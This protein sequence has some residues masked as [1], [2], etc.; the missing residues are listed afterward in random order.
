[1]RI[2]PRHATHLQL[3]FDWMTRI[4]GRYFLSLAWTTIPHLPM[5]FT[6]EA[7]Q[8]P[9]AEYFRTITD[10]NGNASTETVEAEL[11]TRLILAA[12]WEITDQFTLGLKGGYAEQEGKA[13]VF[14][15]RKLHHVWNRTSQ[16]RIILIIDFIP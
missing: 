7:T 2:G 6:I 8:R 12:G 1:M 16:D 9:S 13:F 11:G 3:G 10:V 14:D 5:S 15:D 4:A